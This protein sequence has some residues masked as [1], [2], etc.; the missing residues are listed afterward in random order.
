MANARGLHNGQDVSNKS[1]AETTDAQLQATIS[2]AI[3]G[4]QDQVKRLHNEIIAQGE[5][6]TATETTL[7]S[8]NSAI[9]I[10]QR[11]L[12]ALIIGGRPRQTREADPC[13]AILSNVP[14]MRKHELEL[15]VRD[16]LGEISHLMSDGLFCRGPD[17]KHI[18]LKFITPEAIQAFVSAQALGVRP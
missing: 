8:N 1:G 7:D 9:A 12:A 2:Q 6:L 11:D 10:L 3:S 13:L 4:V 14:G 5:R 18:F 15:L 17:G 16:A